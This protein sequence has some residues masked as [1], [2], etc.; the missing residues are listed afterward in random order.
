MLR[1]AEVNAQTVR[2][3]AARLLSDTH[4]RLEATRIGETFRATG[5]MTR[6]ADEIEDLLRKHTGGRAQ[7]LG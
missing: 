3:T 2:E 6:A 7:P 5:G 4:F 1:K